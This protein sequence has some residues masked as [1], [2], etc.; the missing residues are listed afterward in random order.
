MRWA[1]AILASMVIVV[2]ARTRAAIYVVTNTNDS[3]PGSL[4]RAIDDANASA[5]LDSIHFDIP[6]GGPHTIQSNIPETQWLRLSHPA[7]I[8][9]IHFS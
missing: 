4:R 1:S 6:G 9:N 5:G 8:P 7:G 2:A 3:G